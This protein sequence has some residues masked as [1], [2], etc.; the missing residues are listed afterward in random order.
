[1]KKLWSFEEISILSNKGHWRLVL[2]GTIL[3][4]DHL[5]SILTYF[6][7]NWLTGFRREYFQISFGENHPNLHIFGKTTVKMSS[8]LV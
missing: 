5:R 8:Q 6:E 1:M 7:S 2:S 3:K 4:G